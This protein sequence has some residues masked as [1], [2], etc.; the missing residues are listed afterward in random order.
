MEKEI[1]DVSGK[2]DIKIIRPGREVESY[3]ENHAVLDVV[4][5]T[6]RPCSDM[7]PFG[8]HTLLDCLNCSNCDYQIILKGKLVK[9]F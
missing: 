6:E 5:E 7:D 3:I 9:E 1:I 2:K 4:T 8:L